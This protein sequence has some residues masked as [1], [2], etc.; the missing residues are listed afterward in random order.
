M[1]RGFFKTAAAILISV[2]L[3]AFLAPPARALVVV[4]R[5][6]SASTTALEL[7]FRAP[8]A[9]YDSQTPGISRLALTA[10]AASRPSPHG[11]SLAEFVK[12]LGG[13]LSINAYPDLAM[14]G[15]SVPAWEGEN[16]A[17]RL[18]AA[19]FTPSVSDDGLK[20]A[21]R[22]CAI[23]G[24]E[25]RFNGD[26]LLQDALFAHLF[27]SGPAHYAPTPQNALDFSKIPAQDVKAFAARAF[28]A[29]NA[30]VSAAGA[31]D[32]AVM[33]PFA[34]ASQGSPVQPPLDS[35]LSNRPAD[36]TLDAS[37]EGLGFAWT[38][39]AISD[40]KNA[41]AMDF[42]ADYLFDPDHGT[43]AKVLPP[44][45]QV[46]LNGQFITLHDPGVMLL[47]VTGTGAADMRQNVLDA[48]SA[49]Q[50]P[51]DA[52][53]FAA[54]RAAFVYHILSQI[55]TPLS[56]ADNFGWYAGEGN[57]PYAPGSDSGAYLRA[58]EALDPGFVAQ[59][60]Q[61]F[62]QHP[63]LVTLSANKKSQGAA[64]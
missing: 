2:S 28:T 59:A 42:I 29:Q 21:V 52:K 39:P 25:S 30:I 7:W 22:D 38:G 14:V 19:Y 16:A 36:V 31:I 47:T 62:L 41:T 11:T 26:R 34:H 8:S 57:L 27:E 40:E 37:V 32:E 17:K 23:A 9:G 60:A 53:T 50:K 45:S 48:V 35:A 61:R 44:K 6:P 33:A 1:T 12:A 20:A 54:A 64:I 13:T 43:L 3:L 24:T 46:L 10:L 56:R 55:Q 63:S 49:L 5:D 51:M 15:V 18:A 58:A 4:Q